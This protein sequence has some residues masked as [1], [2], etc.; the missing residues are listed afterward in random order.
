LKHNNSEKFAKAN[1]DF[2]HHLCL[3][4]HNH[5]KFYS[6]TL[7]DLRSDFFRTILA[8]YLSRVALLAVKR[9]CCWLRL[10][11]LLCTLLFGSLELGWFRFWLSLFLGS[12]G[13]LAYWSR[14][15]LVNA[16]VSVV[17]F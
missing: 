13:G 15:W 4:C 10:V 9:L 6:I 1:K 12:C 7:V 8:T 16:L 14:I 5:T 11:V 17:L 2:K 3:F